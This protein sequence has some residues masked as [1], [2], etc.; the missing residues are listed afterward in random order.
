LLDAFLEGQANQ[1]WT[2]SQD[3]NQ[4]ERFR[5]LLSG[6]LLNSLNPDQIN[7]QTMRAA[8]AQAHFKNRIELIHDGSDIRKPYARKLPNLTKVR[9]LEG[10]LI[11]G[12]NSFNSLLI[13]DLDKRLHLLK[14]TSY[15]TADDHYGVLAG[16]SISAQQLQWAQIQEV[17]AALKA[18]FPGLP[19]RHLLDRGHDDADLFG[20]IG[21]ELQSEFVIRAK[22]NRN[23]PG[24]PTQ[25]LHQAALGGHSLTA[26]DRF[27]WRGK[28][29]QQAQMVLD[30]G[31]IELAGKAYRVVRCQ[32]YKR[33]GESIFKE[34]MVLITNGLVENHGDA[35]AI[36]QAYLRRS[37]IETVFK[38]L[39]EQ[40]GWE[41]FRVRD[42]YVIQNVLA[43]SYWAGGYFYEQRAELSQDAAVL[44]LC[45]LAKS[46]G[47]VSLHFLLKGLVIVANHLLFEAFVEEAGLTQEDV[48]QLIAYAR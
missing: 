13:S 8:L 7:E 16:V 47:K 45:G 33:T 29:Y 25:K 27:I 37:R 30:W 22:L 35:F 19:I 5:N 32:L 39:K 12:F 43:L 9:S 28:V 6:R 18:Q 21:S 3:A 14:S 2:M 23:Y 20:F 17:D 31:P 41:S 34:P 46:K 1:L 4:F 42:F 44:W 26:L 10:D 15:S 24:D 48:Q 36:Y 38:F 40:L 11:N